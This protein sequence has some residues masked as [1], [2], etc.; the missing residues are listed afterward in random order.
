M[1]RH[2]LDWFTD[3]VAEREFAG[4]PAVERAIERAKWELDHRL[5]GGLLRRGRRL[6]RPLLPQ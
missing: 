2:F 5:L 3:Y 6:L 4:K 1:R